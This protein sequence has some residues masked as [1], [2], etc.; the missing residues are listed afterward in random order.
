MKNEDKKAIAKTFGVGYTYFESWI[1]SIAYVRNI[2][3]HYGRLYNL[4]LRH[5]PP[6]P[7][8]Y[9]QYQQTKQNKLFPVIVVLKLLLKSNNQWNEFFC[10]IK[11]LINKFN[12]VVNLGYNDFPSD[13]ESILSSK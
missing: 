3:A 13:W 8:E 10:F 4:P 5:K 9:A 1:E 6:L 7:S 2:C 12:H 11:Y